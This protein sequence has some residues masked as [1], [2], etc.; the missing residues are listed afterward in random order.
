VRKGGWKKSKPIKLLT[1][2]ISGST[3]VLGVY[4]GKET[5]VGTDKLA[6]NAI[7]SVKDYYGK[8]RDEIVIAEGDRFNTRSFFD[9]FDEKIIIK[10]EVS[11]HILEARRNIRKEAH[12]P[13]FI[14]A[15]KTKCDNTQN[16][17]SSECRVM[18]N[19][20]NGDLDKIVGFLLDQSSLY[21]KALQAT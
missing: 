21:D 1:S 10:V 5:F 7:T 20:N 6:M 2:Y 9:L 4:N 15:I 13:R 14:K 16:R 8:P 17:Y 19:N 11:E 3:R 12:S 18:Q